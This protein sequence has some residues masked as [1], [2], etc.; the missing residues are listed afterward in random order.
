MDFFTIIGTLASIGSI[1]LSIYLFLKSKENTIDKVKRDIVKVLS[2]QIGDRRELTTFEIQ[3]VINSKTREA[4]ITAE[5]ITLNQIIEDLVS[6]TISNPL[7]DKSVKENILTELRKIYFKG[8]IL[9]QIDKLEVETR[10]HPPTEQN[11][12]QLEA[13]LKNIIQSRDRIKEDLEEQHRKYKKS[14]EI[15]AVIATL[16]TMFSAIL[17]FVGKDNYDSLVSEPFYDYLKRNDFYVAIITSTLAG[18]LSLF[19]LSIYKKKSNK[20]YR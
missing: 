1:P 16:T 19:I 10:N 5:K 15:F 7:L 6:E 8:E 2:H 20:N 4:K 12:N 18:L 11:K 13:N 17:I 9:T 14:S 3:T